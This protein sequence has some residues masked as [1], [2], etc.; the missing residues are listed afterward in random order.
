MSSNCELVVQLARGSNSQ[1]SFVFKDINGVPLDL[2]GSRFLMVLA[3]PAT[4]PLL[5]LDT[6][7]D[8]TTFFIEEDATIIP[9]D[10]APY[11]ADRLVWARTLAQSRQVPLGN[12]TRWEIERRI[13]GSQEFWGQGR[14]CGVGGLPPDA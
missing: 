6:A 13:D 8:T 12:L 5:T 11:T 4:S 10:G 1:I 3:T 14:F 2:A 7:V 9:E